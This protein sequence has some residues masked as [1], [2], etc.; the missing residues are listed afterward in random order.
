[1]FIKTGFLHHK[2]QKRQVHE[3]NEWSKVTQNHTELYMPYSGT[4]SI[5]E[6]DSM[7]HSHEILGIINL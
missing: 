5:V 4:L 7:K 6:C 3:K 1:M 2:I